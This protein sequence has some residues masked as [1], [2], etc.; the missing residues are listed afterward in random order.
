MVR[1]KQAEDERTLEISVLQVILLSL[2]V[3]SWI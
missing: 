1:L 3:E 2:L